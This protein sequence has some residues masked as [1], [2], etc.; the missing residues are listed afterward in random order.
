MTEAIR[1]L[2]DD[3]ELRKRMGETGHEKALWEF[4]LDRMLRET[5]RVY[6]GVLREVQSGQKI[7]GEHDENP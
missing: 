3:P 7:R 4:T 6:H 1:K 5:E 2:L